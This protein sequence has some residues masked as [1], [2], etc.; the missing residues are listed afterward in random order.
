MKEIIVVAPEQYQDLA[1]KITHQISKQ[2]G[3]NGA[4]W[5]IKHYAD[6]EFQLGGNRYVVLVGNPDENHFTKDYL[7]VI[8]NLRNQAGAC[9][10]FDGVKAVIFGEGRLEQENDFKEVLKKKCASLGV[11]GTAGLSVGA[12]LAVGFAPFVTSILWPAAVVYYFVNRSSRIK[13]LRQ[14]QTKA[15]LTLFMAEC[16]DDWAGI[17]KTE[18]DV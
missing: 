9:Y 1:R 11:A 10:G 13:K 17:R 5:T 14:D 12:A 18:H 2:P 16:F 6:N 3:Y 4:Y 7:Q 15:A 8:S